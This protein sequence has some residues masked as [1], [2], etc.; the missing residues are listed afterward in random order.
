MCF[1]MGWS[2]AINAQETTV[3]PKMGP[4]LRVRRRISNV[5]LLRVPVGGGTVLIRSLRVNVES[6]PENRPRRPVPP[7]ELSIDMMAKVRMLVL[8]A[9]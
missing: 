9:R 5:P 7:K 8:A 3:S 6:G 2:H 1:S 4:A